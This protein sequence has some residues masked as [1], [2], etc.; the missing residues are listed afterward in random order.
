MQTSPLCEG[1]GAGRDGVNTH[2]TTRTRLRDRAGHRCH[3]VDNASARRHAVVALKTVAHKL[4]RAGYYILR[5]Q[6]P[7]DVNKACA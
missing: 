1:T 2:V 5:D 7:F 6:V 4:A 3:S